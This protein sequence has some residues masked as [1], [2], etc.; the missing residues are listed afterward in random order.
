M[1]LDGFLLLKPDQW[2]VVMSTNLIGFSIGG[3]CKR[4]LVTPPSMIWPANLGTA[5]L[6]NTL[7]SQETSGTH[8]CRGVSR[9]RFLTYV[10]VGYTLYS[11]RFY[12]G[13][14]HL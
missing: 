9:G 6:F 4:I 13:K 12:L 7:H 11:Q 1:F 14:Y 5:A 3:L 10:F 2:L 8:A